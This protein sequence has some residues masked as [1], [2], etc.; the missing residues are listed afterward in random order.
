MEIIQLSLL[1]SE[2]FVIWSLKRKKSLNCYS[3]TEEFIFFITLKYAPYLRRIL[4][5]INLLIYLA[6][7]F[8]PLG[9]RAVLFDCFFIRPVEKWDSLAF[10]TGGCFLNCW[11]SGA[12]RGPIKW[13]ARSLFALRS[14][15]IKSSSADKFAAI[16]SN[17]EG[18]SAFFIK[19]K[20]LIPSG[21]SYSTRT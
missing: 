5:F 8:A 9:H 16:C 14:Q 11:P 12:D 17:C 19:L 3:I 6:F 10:F 2:T 18:Q 4:I 1:S 21:L 7:Y 15:L 13:S 20:E